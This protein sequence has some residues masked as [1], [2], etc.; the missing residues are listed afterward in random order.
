MSTIPVSMAPGSSVLSLPAAV[1]HTL[2]SDQGNHPPYIVHGVHYLKDRGSRSAVFTI[3]A[4]SLPAAGSVL[5]K[6]TAAGI[7]SV[8][9]TRKSPTFGALGAGGALVGC[10]GGLLG[11]ALPGIGL[12]MLF[13]KA[14]VY[15]ERK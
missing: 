6:L 14:D 12:R 8:P 1:E 13:G 11:G 10:G 5:S 2:L 7:T 15:T 9:A 3:P 4:P